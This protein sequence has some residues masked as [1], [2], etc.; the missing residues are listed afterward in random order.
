VGFDRVIITAS[1]SSS[2]AAKVG[3]WLISHFGI[4]MV[5]YW[6]M[7]CYYFRQSI[8]FLGGSVTI[9]SGVGVTTDLDLA[10]ATLPHNNQSE[11][12]HTSQEGN[13]S[14]Y[15]LFVVLIGSESAT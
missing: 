8:K 6:H 2:A 1:S 15:C 9:R 5:E 14:N 10:A 12:V 7:L 4:W 11:V 3:S 13:D